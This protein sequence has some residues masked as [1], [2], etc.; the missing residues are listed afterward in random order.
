[1]RKI[2]LS[3]LCFVVTC[4]TF[5]QIK[6]TAGS[7]GLGFKITGISNVAFADWRPD[8]FAVPQML[9]RYYFSEKLALRT[10]LG[11]EVLNGKYSFEDRYKTVPN[12]VFETQVNIDTTVQ[13]TNFSFLPGVEYHLAS[14]ASKLDPYVAL[15]A[16]IAFQGAKSTTY[17]NITDSINTQANV[18][19]LHTELRRAQQRPGGLGIN[20]GILGGFNYFFSENFAIGAEYRLGVNYLTTGGKVSDTYSLSVTPTGPVIPET[21]T[22]YIETNTNLDLKLRATGGINISVFW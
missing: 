17:Q 21:T 8:N 22:S 13:Q 10:G 9:F 15:E 3:A 16:G 11:V 20:A 12:S 1:M 7:T 19:V 2:F 5:A 14:P 18:V 6:P 4:A